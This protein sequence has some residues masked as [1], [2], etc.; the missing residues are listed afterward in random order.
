M[1][2]VIISE[3]S[4]S[5]CIW[6]KDSQ[7]YL[8]NSFYFMFL[9]TGMDEPDV[10]VKTLIKKMDNVTMLDIKELED[11]NEIAMFVSRKL[12]H[13]YEDLNAEFYFLKGNK[14]LYDIISSNTNN[15]LKMEYLTNIRRIKKINEDKKAREERHTYDDVA[16]AYQDISS[17]DTEDESEDKYKRGARARPSDNK[18]GNRTYIPK[19]TATA[20]LEKGTLSDIEKLIFIEEQEEVK[21]DEELSEFDI[22]KIG[23]VESLFEKIKESVSECIDCEDVKSITDDEWLKFITTIAKTDDYIQFKTGWKL[24]G[25]TSFQIKFRE[26]DYIRIKKEVLYYLNVCEMLYTKNVF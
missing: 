25:S 21:I 10:S 16:K 24:S 11:P 6:V 5:G 3:Y 4:A 1:A 14:E 20:K 9:E 18:D 2:V 22:K 23:F 26:D 7:K 15:Q 8:D 17:Q 12:M 19:N 13:R